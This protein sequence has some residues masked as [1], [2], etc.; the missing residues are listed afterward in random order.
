MP[1]CRANKLGR[2]YGAATGYQCFPSH[3]KRV[4]LP[5]V[6][7][8]AAGR[9]TDNRTPKGYI[10]IAPDFAAEVVSPKD[11]YERVQ[12]K[13]MDY[14]D[15]KVR[16]IW[17]ISPETKTVLVRRLDGTCAELDEAGELSGED[18]IPGFTC[19]IAELFV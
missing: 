13:I 11:R 16:L 1:F 19:K 17:G 8:V 9:L 10:L 4:R 18:V 15:A 7:F 5:D 3:P 12:Q 6:S 14:K 2:V